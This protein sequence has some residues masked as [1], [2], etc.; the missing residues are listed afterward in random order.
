MTLRTASAAVAATVAA[1]ALAA[2]AAQTPEERVAAIRAEYNATLQ[3]FEPVEPPAEAP[4]AA[5]GV[6][7]AAAAP[8]AADAIA[9]EP[10]AGEAE[11]LGA[12]EAAPS[13]EARQDV[14]LDVLVDNRSDERLPGLTLDVEQAD[15]EREPKATYRIWVDTSQI[16]PGTRGAVTHRLEDVD[17]APGDGFHVEVRQAIP[18]EE[19]GKYRELSEAGEQP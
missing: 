7:E 17:L 8:P 11:Q 3:G 12:D 16:A 18:P 1:A 15:A 5:A 14:L 6:E 9:G 10:V 4:P 19:R 2:C 13:P